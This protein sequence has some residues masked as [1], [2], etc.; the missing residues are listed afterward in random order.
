MLPCRMEVPMFPRL[1]WLA[2]LASALLW[3]SVADFAA[4]RPR[5]GPRVAAPRAPIASTEVPDSE[6]PTNTETWKTVTYPVADLVIPVES[7]RAEVDTLP[8]PEPKEAENVLHSP[9]LRKNEVPA[10]PGK[11]LEGELIQLLIR[12]VA[13]NS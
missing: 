1:L 9:L 3:A 5:R 10:T 6:T 8:R 12:S 11:T 4:A 13:R 7:S 2:G